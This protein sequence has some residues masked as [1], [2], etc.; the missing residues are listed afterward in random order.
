M[1]ISNEATIDFF[2][3]GPST[4]LG[5]T[6]AFR[7]LFCKSIMQ[8]RHQWIFVLCDTFDFVVAPSQSTRDIGISNASRLLAEMAYRRKFWRNMMRSALTYEESRQILIS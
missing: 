1:D 7:V 5:R 3:I 4:I 6:I 2:A 8:L